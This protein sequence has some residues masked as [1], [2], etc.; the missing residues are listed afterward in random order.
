LG[1]VAW[2]HW[3]RLVWSPWVII[4]VGVGSQWFILA[5]PLRE[6]RGGVLLMPLVLTAGAIL[7]RSVSTAVD[8]H[9]RGLPRA[10]QASAI[11]CGV[12][13]GLMLSVSAA[14]FAVAAPTA[15][16]PLF[17]LVCAVCAGAAYAIIGRVGLAWVVLIALY[18]PLPLRGTILQWLTD[19]A[20]PLV[21]L[22]L[23]AASLAGVGH[24]LRMLWTMTEESRFYNTFALW[25]QRGLGRIGVS[26]TSEEVAV[27]TTIE[28][29][30]GAR[31]M[32]AS[33]AQLDVAAQRGQSSRPMVRS[34]RWQVGT[35]PWYV[36]LAMAL[37]IVSPGL[38][39][40]RAIAMPRGPMPMMQWIMLVQVLLASTCIRYLQ[41]SRFRETDILKPVSRQV[42]FREHAI[43][44][45]AALLRDVA[46]CIALMAGL[47]WLYGME[48]GQLLLMTVAAL[49]AGVLTLA[50][51][52]W[53][54]TQASSRF[55]LPLTVGLMVLISLVPVGMAIDA[56]PPLPDLRWLAAL[57]MVGWV[58]AA[59]LFMRAAYRRWMLVGPA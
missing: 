4:T 53:L 8:A 42:L 40:Q 16:L 36:M 37:L 48:M 41:Q 11:V 59:W 5:N 31:W 1:A 27:G 23:V 43:A 45:A 46:I 50:V 2:V 33:P 54:G 30:R 15:A 3:R 39:M 28:R 38:L 24:C 10:V 58:I 56:P 18:V 13:L 26:S 34:L 21:S 35:A 20:H 7:M 9:R 44:L 32:M 29:M 55:S 52:L 14:I 51:S 57:V 6:P 25:G 17:A 49:A 47:T 12:G 19:V 22:G